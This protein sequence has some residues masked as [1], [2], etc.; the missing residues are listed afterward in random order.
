M[1]YSWFGFDDS[2][3]TSCGANWRTHGHISLH[4]TPLGSAT[5]M[6]TQAQCPAL[7]AGVGKLGAAVETGMSAFF[8][9]LGAALKEKADLAIK[10]QVTSS[11]T[12]SSAD[13]KKEARV[14]ADLCLSHFTTPANTLVVLSVEARQICCGVCVCVCVCVCVSVRSR[15]DSVP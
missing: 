11:G 8:D 5:R 7:N 14:R 6:C 13:V 10:L 3:G 15:C 12:G 1:K 4:G 2:C 9:L